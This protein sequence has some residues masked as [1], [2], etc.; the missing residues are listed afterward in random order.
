MLSAYPR[1]KTMSDDEKGDLITHIKISCAHQRTPE[2]ILKRELRFVKEVCLLILEKH[3]GEINDE[4]INFAEL[5]QSFNK[6]LVD[7][8]RIIPKY[9][10]EMNSWMTTKQAAEYMDY[11]VHDI[12]RLTRL[13]LPH[14]EARKHKRRWFINP[15]SIND[16]LI[17]TRRVII[18]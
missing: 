2:G 14:L 3:D 4:S 8:Y 11:S 18:T 13:G 9:H 1:W 5:V 16:L 6:T 7:I 17:R 15:I 10:Q 12:R